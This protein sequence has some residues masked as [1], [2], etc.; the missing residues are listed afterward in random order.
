MFIKTI[1]RK[2]L[3]KIRGDINIEKLQA[4]GLM[5]GKNFKMIGNNIIDPSHCWHIEIGDNVVLAPRAHILAHDASTGLFLGYTKVGN[6]KI[7]NNVFIGAGSI[8]LMGVS[9]GDNVIIGAGSIVTK[10]IPSNS[11]A[12]GNPAVV[13]S[14]LEKY[15]EKE[16]K[17]M[18]DNNTFDDKYTLRN[19]KFSN[20]QRQILIETC[21]KYGKSYVK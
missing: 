4:R 11:V 8:V 13:I 6:V 2:I 5:V 12:A 1:I 18:C 20:K 21:K 19:K 9:I 17:T 14:S 7:G 10:D 3:S 15:I 16:R